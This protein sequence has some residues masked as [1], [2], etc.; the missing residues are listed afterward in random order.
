M[1][2]DV[3]WVIVCVC[4]ARVRLGNKAGDA[5]EKEK[6]VKHAHEAMTPAAASHAAQ[7]AS[8]AHGVCV[9]VLI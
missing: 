5:K 6:A 4:G 8:H 2:V 3:V 7:T 1:C 9:C